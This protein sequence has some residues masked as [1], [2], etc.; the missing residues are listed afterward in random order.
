MPVSSSS[1]SAKAS[2]SAL[3]FAT[4]RSRASLRWGQLRP[5]LALQR[6]QNGLGMLR[7]QRFHPEGV[8]I[9]ISVVRNPLL[10]ARH[11][12]HRGL[13][14]DGQYRRRRDAECG[15]RRESGWALTF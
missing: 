6:K 10:H 7:R 1:L 4:A 12:F 14:Q 2:F 5:E 9:R 13:N 15:N 3:R 8:P 11:Q